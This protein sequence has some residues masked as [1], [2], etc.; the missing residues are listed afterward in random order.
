TTTA[1]PKASGSNSRTERWRHR[2]A[3][4]APRH[5]NDSARP[6]TRNTRSM[7]H[8]LSARIGHCSHSAACGLFRCQCQP[9][10]K[11]MPTWYRMT[12][13]KASARRASMSWRRFMAASLERDALHPGRVVTRRGGDG[14]SGGRQGRMARLL[15]FA[16][17]PISDS[18]LARYLPWR[19]PAEIC[20]WALVLALQ[21]GFNTIVAWLDR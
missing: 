1:M 8:R 18:L 5:R 2:A 17:A 19:R 13:A 11:Y 6:D 12:S 9:A 4:P 10:T 3:A 20:F 15:H 7:R 21:A 16:M 14:T